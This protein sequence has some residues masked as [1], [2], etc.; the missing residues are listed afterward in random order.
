MLA[1]ITLESLPS[2]M[3]ANRSPRSSVLL[4]KA[5]GQSIQI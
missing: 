2:I 4:K 1:A 3:A 5:L